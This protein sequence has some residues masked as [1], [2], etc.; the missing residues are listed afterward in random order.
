MSV[1][2]E[3]M[4]RLSG[5]DAEYVTKRMQKK[6]DLGVD[7]LEVI[8]NNIQTILIE[9]PEIK[10]QV[11]ILSVSKENCIKLI[12]KYFNIKVI[13]MLHVSFQD[14]YSLLKQFMYFDGLDKLFTYLSK[15]IRL[16]DEEFVFAWSMIAGSGALNSY[17]E[18]FNKTLE[19]GQ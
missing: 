7:K 8:L 6:Y 15:T 5:Q 16:A 9:C 18:S 3:A 12:E 2:Q 19:G 11:F 14:T 17:I 10:E 13:S 1:I 4:I